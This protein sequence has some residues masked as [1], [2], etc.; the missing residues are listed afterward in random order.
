MGRFVLAWSPTEWSPTPLVFWRAAS[1]LQFLPLPSHGFSLSMCFY[2][3][4]LFP[5]YLLLFVLNQVWP[6]LSKLYLQKPCFPPPPQKKPH[7]RFWINI[8]FGGN[9]NQLIEAFLLGLSYPKAKPNNFIHIHAYKH[10]SP[11][12]EPVYVHSWT[13]RRRKKV[14]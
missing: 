11:H 14:K 12:T 1:S 5:E 4:F 3:W 10:M 13:Q 2:L 8:C 6:L 9:I 7:M